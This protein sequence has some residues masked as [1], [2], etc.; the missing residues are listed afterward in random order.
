[1]TVAYNSNN[2]YAAK[3]QCQNKCAAV[4]VFLDSLDSRTDYSSNIIVCA[5]KKHEIWYIDSNGP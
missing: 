5:L 2:Y 3:R 4:Q 1:M